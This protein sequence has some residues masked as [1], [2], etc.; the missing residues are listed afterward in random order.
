MN[1]EL[2]S[3]FIAGDSVG[4]VGRGVPFRT[5]VYFWGRR[6]KASTESY[7]VMLEKINDP[8]V[9]IGNAGCLYQVFRRHIQYE[10][11][12]RIEGHVE[13]NGSLASISNFKLTGILDPFI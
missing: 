12:R 2:L 13:C 9:S 6:K 11:M 4:L 5:W 10:W 7:P 8:C 3:C 1:G